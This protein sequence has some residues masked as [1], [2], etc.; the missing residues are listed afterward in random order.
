MRSPQVKGHFNPPPQSPPDPIPTESVEGC[1]GPL[2]ASSDSALADA[3]VPRYDYQKLRTD[4]RARE[5]Q[6][7]HKGEKKDNS[8]AKSDAG[9]FLNRIIE[10]C[11]FI[12]SSFYVNTIGLY[13]IP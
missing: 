3:T 1:D 12:A 6:L 9:K 8:E 11:A 5:R 7:R 2:V 13:I 10:Y 4:M